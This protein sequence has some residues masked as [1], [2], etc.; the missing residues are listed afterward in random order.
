M[1]STLSKN[2]TE[3]NLSANVRSAKIVSHFAKRAGL[4]RVDG[5]L[6]VVLTMVWMIFASC[7]PALAG[8]NPSMCE[9]YA[10]SADTKNVCGLGGPRW[11]SSHVQSTSWCSGARIES[12]A[13][14]A[15][16]RLQDLN[17]CSHAAMC[18]QYARD[19]VAANHKNGEVGC[20]FSGLRYGP[21]ERDHENWCLGAKLEDVY[22]EERGRFYDMDHCTTCQ[23]YEQKAESDWNT[24]NIRGCRLTG[25]RWSRDKKVHVGWCMNARLSSV[26]HEQGERALEAGTCTAH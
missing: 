26:I 10:S 2:Y 14:E 6:L 24:Q 21:N 5:H 11:N 20:G 19:A 18:R 22:N 13:D 7:K 12:V 9:V 3:G 23:V 1:N 8:V 16:G 4:V 25:P 15:V 17:R